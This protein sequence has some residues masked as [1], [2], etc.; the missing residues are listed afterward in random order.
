ME[1]IKKIFDKINDYWK[2]IVAI[3]SI[4][5]ALVGGIW[6]AFGFY[7]D[8]QDKNDEILATL[9]TTQQMALKSVIWNEGIPITDITSACDIYLGAGYNSLTKKRCE[10]IVSNANGIAFNLERSEKN[11]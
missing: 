8:F 2:S 3:T 9:K 1:K 4:I 10:K 11:E 7:R 6:F 5:T